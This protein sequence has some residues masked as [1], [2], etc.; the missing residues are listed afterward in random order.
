M[1]DVDRLCSRD[2]VFDTPTETSLSASAKRYLRKYRKSYGYGAGFYDLS[3]DPSF[4]AR[5][6]KASDP[7][8][9]LT[10]NS[11]NIWSI[12]DARLL[13][14][15]EIAAAQGLPS[16]HALGAALGLAPLDFGSYKRTVWSRLVGNGMSTSCIGAVLSWVAAYAVPS[17]G[18]VPSHLGAIDDNVVQRPPTSNSAG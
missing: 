7:L 8:F 12:A 10:T 9:T 1:S 2:L 4:R 11:S 14:G 17:L 16:H 6:C 13:S 15:N 18:E 3:Q 5:A